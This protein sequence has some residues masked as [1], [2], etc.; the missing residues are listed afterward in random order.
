MK[1][2]DFDYELPPALIAQ[3]PT[4]ERTDARMMLVD[5]ASGR[6]EHLHVRDL[7]QCLHAG[8]LIVVNDTKVINARVMGSKI[9][10]GGKVE[11]LFLEEQAEGR[12]QVLCRSSRKSPV[13]TSFSLANGRIVAE[14]ESI[15]PEGRTTVRVECEGAFADVMAEEGAPPLPPYIKRP[16]GVQGMDYERYQTVYA[17]HDGAVAAPTAGLHFTDELMAQLAALGVRRAAI[18]LH[19]GIGTFRPVAVDDIER[20][21]MGSERYD[22]GEETADAIRETKAG[23]GRVVAIGTT[24]VR[25]LE[26]VLQEQ[27]Q[28]V[29]ASGRSKIFIHPP[30]R[31]RSVDAIL[32]NFHL[33]KSTLLM[34]VSAFAGMDLV[35][36]SYAEAVARKYRFYSYGDSMLII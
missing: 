29:A 22:V 24:T 4:S 8:D 36:R 19:V 11:V 33:P 17:S 20:H 25:A 21:A 13:G 23:G 26:T 9:D 5:R 2:S 30:Y 1:T 34:M 35:R 16:D 31:I 6:L 12:W 3:H 10:T 15:D 7:V 14:V 32:T 18:T 27:G 28:L